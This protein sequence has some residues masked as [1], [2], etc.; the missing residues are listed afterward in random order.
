MVE[1]AV[2]GS[3]SGA[4]LSTTDIVSMVASGSEAANV[5][6][7]RSGSSANA[8]GDAVSGTTFCCG[9]G[10]SLTVCVS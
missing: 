8:A 5:G 9:S 4:S 6:A 3:I 2:A 1:A 7:V 10:A